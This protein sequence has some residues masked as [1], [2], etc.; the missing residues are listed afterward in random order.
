MMRWN[1]FGGSLVFAAV[2]AG[3][4]LVTFPL[5]A[6]VVGAAAALC[7]FSVGIAVVY[8][9]GLAPSWRRGFGAAIVASVLG[10][11][12]L[13]LP[14]G[15]PCTVA[16]AAGIVAVCRSGVLYRQR[17]LRALVAEAGLTAGGLALASFLAAGGLVSWAL[18]AWGY[19]LVQSVF[20]LVGGVQPRR[21]G[22]PSDPFDR[23]REELLTLIN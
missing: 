6:P 8:L 17:T 15:V 9:V 21:E 18:A 19:F 2:A 11:I 20:F 14:F 1:G 10:A 22:G 3:A 7:L 23:A 12:L 13:I 4:L 16:G 5:L